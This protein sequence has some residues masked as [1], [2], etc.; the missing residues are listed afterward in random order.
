MADY[1]L[2]EDS[3]YPRS[4]LGWDGTDFQVIGVDVTGRLRVGLIPRTYNHYGQ[5]RQQVVELNPGAGDFHLYG[6]ACPAGAI[7][8]VTNIVAFD[9]TTNITSI[10]LGTRL[11]L[12]HMDVHAEVVAAAGQRIMWNG[13]IWLDPTYQIFAHFVGSLVGDDLYLNI[14]GHYMLSVW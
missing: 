14:H 6:T 5:Y 9:N 4:A 12:D 13:E 2:P 10:V 7:Y 3:P 11:G 1:V 8:K